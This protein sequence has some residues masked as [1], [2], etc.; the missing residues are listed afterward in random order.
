MPSEGRRIKQ[1]RW[2]WACWPAPAALRAASQLGLNTVANAPG[3]YTLV[4]HLLAL[5]P[6]AAGATFYFDVFAHRYVAG[7]G[8]QPRR[9]RRE[10]SAAVEGEDG[11]TQSTAAYHRKAQ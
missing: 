4:P 8:L 2:Q 7:L 1:G 9:R 6:H 11:D 5:P 3:H 10:G